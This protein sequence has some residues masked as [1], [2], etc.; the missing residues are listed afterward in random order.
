MDSCIPKEEEEEEEEIWFVT[1]IGVVGVK[2]TL[3][4][5]SKIVDLGPEIIGFYTVT[6]TCNI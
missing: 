1:L 3:I 4:T 5:P 2:C 6:V